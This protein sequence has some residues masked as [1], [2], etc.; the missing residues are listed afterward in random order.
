VV[1]LRLQL[2]GGLYLFSVNSAKVTLLLH[3]IEEIA[4]ILF[5]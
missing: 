5:S 4:G 3:S 2:S 1:S